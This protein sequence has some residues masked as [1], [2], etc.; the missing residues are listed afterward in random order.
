V[1]KKQE[2]RVAS[3]FSNNKNIKRRPL[4]QGMTTP[5][6]QAY[7]RSNANAFSRWPGRQP[8][9]RLEPECWPQITPSFSFDKTEPIFA[10]GDCFARNIEHHLYEEGFQIAGYS[11]LSNNCSKDQYMINRYSPA[12]IFQELSWVH[13]ILQRDGVVTTG[14]V[15]Q[16]LIEQPG[17]KWLDINTMA[18]RSTE[19]SLEEIRD[20]RQNLFDIFKHAFSSKVII[21]TLDVI[22]SWWDEQTGLYVLFDNNLLARKDRERFS[23]TRMNFN[24]CHDFLTKTIALLKKAG[25]EKILLAVSPTPNPRTYSP[26]DA[27]VANTYS[28]SVLRAVTGQLAEEHHGV[29]YFPGYETTML[30]RRAEIWQSDLIHVQTDFVARIAHHLTAEYVK[31]N[32]RSGKAIN[33]DAGLSMA[34]Q[35][36]AG[37][38]GAA[39]EIY[40]KIKDDIFALQNNQVHLSAA[41]LWAHYGNS[42]LALKH[43]EMVDDSEA[44]F[45]TAHPTAFYSISQIYRKA[46][47]TTKADALLNKF[48][49]ASRTLPR[50]M[51]KCLIGLYRTK[52]REELET[53]VT[54]ADKAEIGSSEL[55]DKLAYWYCQ[56][57]RFDDA[58]RICKRQ[59]ANDPG[60]INLQGRLTYIYTRTGEL[61]KAIASC[62]KVIEMAP[63]FTKARLKLVRYLIK[64]DN[65]ERARKAC[66]ALTR[67][68]PENAMAHAM[69]AR[70][71][72]RDGDRALARQNGTIALQLGADDARVRH[73][74]GSIVPD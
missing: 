39:F 51:L 9:N 43:A 54:I 34:E 49:D 12:S 22:E 46:G 60:N 16:W 53:L 25:C 33:L 5:I 42:D 8:D 3:H 67:D 27:I 11:A 10:I 13:K 32:T 52:N 66:E 15:R 14:D 56:T 19:H 47:K 59:L 18:T 41:Q 6:E 45:C 37:E 26:D 74:V 58:E 63:S 1:R 24:E 31:D 20:I 62:E 68:H 71:C 4:L 65:Y 17:G 40:A 7:D 21:I 23:F 73:E 69:L 38:F 61:N 35:V 29:D 57:D 36:S 2:C 48:I 28:K 30:T 72:W 55:I 64:A 44:G 50:I 70:L